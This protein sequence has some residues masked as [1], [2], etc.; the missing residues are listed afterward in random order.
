MMKTMTIQPSPLLNTRAI[1]TRLHQLKKSIH[2]T[3]S[4]RTSNAVPDVLLRRAL[5]E[6][7]ETAEATG[8]PL[9]VFPVL[10]EETVARVQHAVAEE[11]YS[12][13][14]AEPMALACCA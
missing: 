6:A 1:S 7:A 3:I 10:A 8:F 2:R 14:P 12:L 5:D 9:L 4:R 11:E 13:S